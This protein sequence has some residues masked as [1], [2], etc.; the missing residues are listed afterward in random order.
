MIKIFGGRMSGIEKYAEHIRKTGFLLEF[1]VTKALEKH[2]WNVVTNKY[3]VDD[4]QESVREIDLVAYKISYVDKTGIYTTL[5]VSCK[6]SDENVWTL[7]S[8]KPNHSDPN[9]DWNPRHV[10]SNDKSIE[11]ML[12]IEDSKHKYLEH[13]KENSLSYFAEKPKRHIFAFQE[14]AKESGKPKNDKAI[15]ESVT[16]LMKAQTYE[17]G[18]LPERKAQASKSVYHFALLN[19]VGTDLICLD[20]SDDEI[21]SEVVLEEIYVASYIVNKKHMF[22]RIHFLN[23]EILDSALDRYDALHQ[24]NVKFYR[25][26]SEEFYKSAISNR[27]KR[28]V[29]KKEFLADLAFRAELQTDFEPAWIKAKDIYLS[30]MADENVLNLYVSGASD[31]KIEALNGDKVK[32]EVAELLMQYYRYAGKFRFSDTPF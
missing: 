15:F 21:K 23:P 13:L 4:V 8:R 6:K 16:S 28:N 20:F 9:I 32:K 29:F 24:A 12:G 14:M 30:W 22:S 7:L 5:V 27:E 1:N 26:S 3:Y 19:I 2:G 17:M 25:K 31:Q 18:V 10:W 11:H